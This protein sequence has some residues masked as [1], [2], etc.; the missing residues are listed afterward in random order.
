MKTIMTNQLRIDTPLKF[1]TFT[2]A[3]ID[4][5][6]FNRIKAYI[7]YARSSSSTTKIVVGGDYDDSVGF[8]IQPT[9]IETTDPKDKLMREEIFGPVVTVYVYDDKKYNET[10]D[11]VNQ[12]SNYALTGSI[13]CQDKTVL[14]QTRERLI[15][16]AGN[17]Y[18][19]DKSTGSIVNQQPFGGAR[20][21]GTNDK[22]GGPH[23]L[24]RFSSPLAIKNMKQPL[25]TFKH[26]SME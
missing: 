20:L 26:V 8:Y 4:R 24:F 19:N 10:V 6:S 14:N 21:S 18:L 22:A 5:N 11:L 15:N 2:S 7:D 3:V 17:I 25:K 23:Y 12:T 9:L 13:F 1:E 16:A